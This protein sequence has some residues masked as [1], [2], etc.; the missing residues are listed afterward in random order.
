[1]ALRDV[2][3]R[4]ERGVVAFEPLAKES[5]SIVFKVELA[6]DMPETHR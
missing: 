5:E 4:A 6:A 1:V 3:E 2:A